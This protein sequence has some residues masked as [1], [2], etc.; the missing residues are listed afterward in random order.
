MG[1]SLCT[2]QH[3]GASDLLAAL[4][5]SPRAVAAFAAITRAERYSMLRRLH[6]LKTAQGRASNISRIVAKLAGEERS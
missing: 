2:R 4:E 3:R 5:A 6:H 1:R